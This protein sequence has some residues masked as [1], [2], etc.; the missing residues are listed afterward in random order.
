MQ[1][2]QVLVSK[3]VSG[4]SDQNRNIPKRV[5]SSC[6]LAFPKSCV[7]SCASTYEACITFEYCITYTGICGLDDRVREC[8]LKSCHFRHRL[9]R[10]DSQPH[11]SLYSPSLNRASERNAVS[12]MKTFCDWLGSMRRFDMRVRGSHQID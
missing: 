1:V 4:Q 12:T 10:V 2:F 3:R 9:A 8:C 6:M 7:N 5:I 11:P